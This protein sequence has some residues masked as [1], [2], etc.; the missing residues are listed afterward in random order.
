MKRGIM[1][2]ALAVAVMLTALTSQA[3]A[4]DRLDR[5]PLDFPIAGPETT[6]KRFGLLGNPKSE[7]PATAD[8]LF[9][10]SI[11]P[12]VGLADDTH[13]FGVSVGFLNRRLLGSIPLGLAVTDKYVSVADQGHN[14]VQ[15]DA[16]LTV[17]TLTTIGS[18]NLSFLMLGQ[19]RKTADIS[20]TQQGVVEI[21]ATLSTSEKRSQSLAAGAVAYLNNAKPQ[22]GSSESGMTFGVNLDLTLNK[23]AEV[24]SEYDFKSDFAGEDDYSIQATAVVHPKGFIGMKALVGWGKHDVWL[25]GV[26]STFAGIIRRRP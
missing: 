14:R 6:Q 24:V 1:P 16:S 4:Q 2:H 15:F 13:S 23:W 21:D 18:V 9:N 7:R 17:P 25:F 8:T 22:G 10:W 3:V 26:K 5:S 19:Y 20:T 12:T 11:Y